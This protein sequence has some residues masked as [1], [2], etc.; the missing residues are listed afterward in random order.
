MVPQTTENS[1]FEQQTAL[2]FWASS[3]PQTPGK[4][5]KSP[6][7]SQSKTENLIYNSLGRENVL[8]HHKE[9]HIPLRTCK[10]NIAGA[11]VLEDGSVR[12]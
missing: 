1:N 2:H 9:V 7:D 11:D 3:S 8:L 12:S 6:E 4:I 5:S 10:E